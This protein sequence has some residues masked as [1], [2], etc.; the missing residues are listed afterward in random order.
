MRKLRSSRRVLARVSTNRA[1][2]VKEPMTA[3][4]NSRR[5]DGADSP[6]KKKKE[7]KINGF[8]VLDLTN[9]YS[10]QLRFKLLFWASRRRMCSEM[11]DSMELDL[12]ERNPS[13][14]KGAEAYR[15]VL[16]DA[17]QKAVKDE[18]ESAILSVKKKTYAS[19]YYV[20][21][22]VWRRRGDP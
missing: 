8:E 19:A 17:E 5:M 16:K 6:W 12:L 3:V 4:L 20:Y 7:K 1:P 11:A 9:V 13:S 14:W 21:I 22:F 15:A 2:C 10:K 18:L